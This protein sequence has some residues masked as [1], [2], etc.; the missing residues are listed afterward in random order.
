MTHDGA[1]YPRLVADIGGTNARFGWVAEPGAPISDAATYAARAYPGLEAVIARYLADRPG[2]TA[3]ASAAI[4]VAVPVDRDRLTMT[5]LA[6]TFSLSELRQGL[7][8]ERLVVL[9]DY[10]ALALALPMLAAHELR[11]VGGGAP[12][13][14][15][16]LAVLG[17]GTGL[18]VSGL[19]RAGTLALPIPGDGGHVTLA[20][21][22]AAEDRVV[23][24]LRQRFGHV[25]AER[26]LS[27]SGLVNL[28]R[29]RCEIAGRPAEALDAAGITARDAAGSD[30]ECSAAVDLFFA[31]LGNV[32]GNLALTFGALGGVYIGGGI[33]P[34]LGDRIA[35]SLF[36]SRFEAKGRFR[37]YLAAIPAWVIDPSAAPAL[38]GANRALD[39]PPPGARSA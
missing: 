3:L 28:Y 36:R 1:P 39:A 37:D 15:A 9:N 24:L 10:A 16:P 31:F 18:G 4:A 32:A 12:V 17:A 33:V 5:N 20:A 7:G 26:A 23:E 19:V 8:L 35:G 6:W 14:D 25:S 29:A 21:T 13:A 2:R 38:R 34:R 27:G 22:D 30:A 11:Q